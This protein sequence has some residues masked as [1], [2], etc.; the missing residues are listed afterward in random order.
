MNLS[1]TFPRTIFKKA[2]LQF[3]KCDDMRCLYSED[4][5]WCSPS[6]ERWEALCTVSVSCCNDGHLHQRYSRAT[7]G[8]R[9]S[10]TNSSNYLDGSLSTHRVA[11]RQ[12]AHR[13]R[14]GGKH[15]TEHIC[16]LVVNTEARLKRE[17]TY[18]QSARCHRKVGDERWS[19]LKCEE[20][21]R[22]GGNTEVQMFYISTRCYRSQRII[23]MVAPTTTH[24][25]RGRGILH[26]FR[27]SDLVFTPHTHTHSKK[28]A[29]TRNDYIQMLQV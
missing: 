2:L 19:L 13:R 25:T 1:S 10:E 8:L 17:A 23:T 21:E 5:C 24:C 7:S 14:V 20:Q 4:T 16:V 9:H 18:L 3:F 11:A 26:F 6:S 15:W 29:Q 28:T 27:L 22:E 12:D